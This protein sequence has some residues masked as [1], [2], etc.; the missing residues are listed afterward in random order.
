MFKTFLKNVVHEHPQVMIMTLDS[1]V[2]IKFDNYVITCL[3][4]KSL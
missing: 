3:S 1:Q 4:L 2:L